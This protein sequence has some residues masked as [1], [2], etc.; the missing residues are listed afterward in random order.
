MGSALTSWQAKAASR[1]MLQDIRNTTDPAKS[2]DKK[3]DNI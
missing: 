1:L 2:V 3:M